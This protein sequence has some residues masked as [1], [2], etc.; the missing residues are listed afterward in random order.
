MASSVILV[1]I[2][3]FISTLLGGLF[4]VRIK[5]KLHLV[6]GFA[7]GAVLGVALFELW[8]EAF[9]QSVGTDAVSITSL[10]VAGGFALYLILDRMMV[11]HSGHHQEHSDTGEHKHLFRG[12]IGAGSLSLHSY[13]DG[14]AVG[15]AFASSPVVGMVVAAAVLAHDFSDGINTVSIVLRHGGSVRRAY[16]WLAVDAITPMAGILTTF[17]IPGLAENIGRLLAVFCGFFLYIGASD[18]LPES[19]HA[20]PTRWTTV[21][22]LLG[23]GF[24]FIVT[25]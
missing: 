21:A 10:F 2:A 3:T 4:A 14:L 23:M 15:L 24:I 16:R 18:L 6:T 11:L 12:H 13:M 8:P 1:G 7:A 19:H 9:A 25:R 17:L 20:H 5:D 22:T